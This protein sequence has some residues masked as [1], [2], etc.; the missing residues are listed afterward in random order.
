MNGTGFFSRLL[1]QDPAPAPQARRGGGRQGRLRR[2]RRALARAG[3][4]GRP[5]GAADPGRALRG[6]ARASCR[7]SSRRPS[8]SARRRRRASSPRRPSW[9]RSTSTAAARRAASSG[10]GVARR[11]TRARWRALFPG[12]V[13]VPPDHAE[14]AKWNRL[15]AEAGDAAAQVRLGAAV[16]HRVWAWRPDY[17]EAEHWFQAA[18]AQGHRRRRRSASACSTA[19]ATPARPTWPGRRSGSRSPPRAGNTGAQFSLAMM[20][21]RGEGVEKDEARAAALMAQAAEGGQPEPMYLFGQFRRMGIGGPVDLAE[22]ETWLRRAAARG[23]VKAMVAVGAVLTDRRPPDPAAASVYFRQAADLGDAE[24]QFA[25]GQLYLRGELGPADGRGGRQ[26]VHCRGRA[27]IRR[28]LRAAGRDLRRGAG[29]RGATTRRPPPGSTRPPPRATPRR[30]TAWASCIAPGWACRRTPKPRRTGSRRPPAAASPRPACGWA[31][32]WPQANWA[33]RTTGARPCSGERRR[34]RAAWTPRAIWRCCAS[35][36]RARR[37][38]KAMGLRL[39]EEAAER[40][41]RAAH[42]ALHNLFS[43]GLDVAADDQAAQ[44]WLVKAAETGDGA[45]ACKLA[46]QLETHHP[47]ALPSDRVLALLQQA[48]EGGETLAQEQLGR[49]YAEGRYAPKSQAEALRWFSAAAEGGA[50]F[51]QAWLGDMLNA[52]N[53]APKDQRAALAWYCKAAEGGYLPA[54]TV[55]THAALKASAPPE[56]VEALLAHWRKAARAGRCAGAADDGRLHAE[57]R[58][59]RSLDPGR[60]RMAAQSRRPGRPP[61]K[62]ML[63]GLYLKGQA[64]PRRGR[65]SDPAC[66]ARRPSRATPTRNTIWASVIGRAWAYEPDCDAGRD[67]DI[68]QAAAAKHR[69]AQ[70]ALAELLASTPPDTLERAAE[71]ARWYAEA[72]QGGSGKAMHRLGQ[73]HEQGRG[74]AARSGSGAAVLPKRRGAGSRRGAA[75]LPAP[76]GRSGA[77]KPGGPRRPPVRSAVKQRPPARSGACIAVRRR[78]HRAW[79]GNLLANRWTTT[80][81]FAEPTASIERA[82][83]SPASTPR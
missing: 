67:L 56:A 8:C 66:C 10:R 57:G 45:A 79:L 78:Q 34:S 4:G 39:L 51:A 25:L 64:E 21:W 47:L 32:S 40:G 29:S 68:A 63:A 55:L 14:A 48:A 74:V 80:A 61:A 27:G 36:G 72:A 62:V 22:A 19:A 52:G 30:C 16:R 2:V 31:R 11:T 81:P 7:A 35:A 33:S 24:A 49:F 73:M 1:R 76:Y 18:A 17:A 54:L 69:S 71:A 5:D 38:D 65:G 15:A 50:P 77:V 9:A 12:E 70:L 44:A 23:H 13:S 59:G 28:R 20:Y 42:W 75:G 3:R 37:R 46:L 26:V 82:E 6:R 58:R 53:G 43:E 60:G 83:K 41:S